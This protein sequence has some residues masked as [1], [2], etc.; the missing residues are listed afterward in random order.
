MATAAAVA[1][2]NTPLTLDVG[3]AGGGLDLVKGLLEVLD[4]LH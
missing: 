1:V 2:E 3:D 4:A